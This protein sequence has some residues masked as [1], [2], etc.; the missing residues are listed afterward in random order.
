MKSRICC[1]LTWSL[2]AASLSLHGAVQEV[3]VARYDGGQAVGA[4]VAIALD[5]QG[6]LIVCGH[7]TSTNGDYDYLTL[8]YSPSGTLLWSARYGSGPG[9]SD[10]VLAM[11]VGADGNVYVTGTSRTVK[12]DS[13]GVLQWVAPY[14]ARGLALDP[15][16]DVCITGFSE[17]TYATAKLDKEAGTNLWVRTYTYLNR[18]GYGDISQTI[19]VDSR[20][21]IY[22]GGR[23]YC[24]TG[25]PGAVYVEQLVLG[26]DTQG[27]Q[28]MIT[29]PFPPGGCGNTYLQLVGLGVDPAGNVYYTVATA[30]DGVNISKYDSSG[31]LQWRQYG[32]YVHYGLGAMACDSN[33]FVYLTGLDLYLG[34]SI[35]TEKHSPFGTNVWISR[36]AGS[37]WR[38]GKAVTVSG[39]GEVFVAGQVR[40]NTTDDDYVT[41]K[42]DQD[43]REQWAML[44]DGPAHS[45]DVATAIAVAP[46]GS[47]YVSGTSM[48]TNGLLEITTIKYAQYQPI[49]WQAG[50]LVLVEFAS[51]NSQPCRLQ[52]SANLTLWDDLATLTPDAN[53]I[54]HYTDTN[55][56]SFPY[57]FYRML[58]P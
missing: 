44:Y 56:P 45:T 4:N 35:G 12:Y 46:D 7:G 54:A 3:W 27:N 5:P 31:V 25:R 8:K 38:F 41:I 9:I 16:G 10:Q 51:S 42:Y 24:H 20:S 2:L 33:G 14:A 29:D 40:S 50:G 49:A 28:I 11:A 32:E 30:N 36:Y 13:N 48:N 18:P 39:A 37:T 58:C 22:V 43:G 23:V 19:A 57:R 53:H 15:H 26:Y 55:T 17:S 52:A 34:L 21:N 1:L 6:S 47:V